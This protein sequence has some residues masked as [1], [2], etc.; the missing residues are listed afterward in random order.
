MWKRRIVTTG[1]TIFIS[2]A[3]EEIDLAIIIKSRLEMDFMGLPN[4]FVSSDGE[5]I[6]AGE[7]WLERINSVLSASDIEI[8]LCSPTSLQRP[9][10]NFEAGAGWIKGI[11]VI[12]ICHS[13]I[14]PST[15]PVPLNMLQGIN[16]TDPMGWSL[17]YKRIAQIMG[18]RI[19]NGLNFQ[20]LIAEIKMTMKD[21]ESKSRKIS[22][23]SWDKLS[24]FE[25]EFKTRRA[26]ESELKTKVL[27]ILCGKSLAEIEIE[28]K[29]WR[30]GDKVPVP[31]H[32]W[33][34]VVNLEPISNSN[35]TREFGDTCSI[36]EEGVLEIVGFFEE[37]DV[38]HTLLKFSTRSGRSGA[39]CPNGVLFVYPL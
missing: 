5:S 30:V 12:P 4:V 19:P 32:R 9:W 23:P 34:E 38:V 24:N 21:S 10:V 15:L 16:A 3:S 1:P 14:S 17:V 28:G 37:N 8:I 36:D 33:V 18:A 26:K 20:T 2:H 11:P 25:E 35:V 13:G 29:I 39:Q 22:K 27:E 31:S 7:K 6:L